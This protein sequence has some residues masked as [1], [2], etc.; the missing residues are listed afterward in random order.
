MRYLF[1]Y[2][3]SDNSVG[4][5]TSFSEFESDEAALADI[6]EGMEIEEWLDDQDSEGYT[7]LLILNLDTQVKLFT[8]EF[9]E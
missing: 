7:P 1:A 3:E 6:T 5:K 4:F 2:L 8:A 9:D